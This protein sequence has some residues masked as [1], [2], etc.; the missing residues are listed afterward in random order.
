MTHFR[1]YSDKNYTVWKYKETQQQSCA[2]YCEIQT[3]SA[4]DF[5]SILCITRLTVNV[6]AQLEP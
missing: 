6:E 2:L 1:F 3:E 5:P 4:A